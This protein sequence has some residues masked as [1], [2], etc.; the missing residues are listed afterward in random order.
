MSEK[1]KKAGARRHS[2]PS[3]PR[4]RK[5]SGPF[6]IAALTLC[7]TAAGTA[8][9]WR[10][11]LRRGPGLP[12]A[13][14]PARR[15][16]GLALS[17]EYIYVGGRLVATEEPPP[18][19]PPPVGPPPGELSASATGP[20]GAGVELGWTAPADGAVSGCLVER[21]RLLGGDLTTLSENVTLTTFHDA[22]AAPDTAYLYYVRAVF[23]GGGI[24]A[25]SDPDVATTVAF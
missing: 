10:T 23:E 8:S 19:G 18:A 24:S 7:A 14:E 25:R 2:P 21:R 17:K 22:T 6:V 13:V 12:A 15:Q 16:D 9:V 4:R 3:G 5:A 11:P 20:A 1:K